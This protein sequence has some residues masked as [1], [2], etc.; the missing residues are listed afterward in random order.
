MMRK[1]LSRLGIQETVGRNLFLNHLSVFPD[2]LLQSDCTK[3]I[4]LET[5][6]IIQ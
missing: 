6:L 3:M 2:T 4:V 1:I 5:Q